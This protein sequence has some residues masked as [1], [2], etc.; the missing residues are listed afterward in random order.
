MYHLDSFYHKT[1]ILAVSYLN[2]GEAVFYL[3]QYDQNAN[4]NLN[5]AVNEIRSFIVL[6]S[7]CTI[8][9][10]LIEG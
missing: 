9:I 4:H 7:T 2:E 10:N 1:S 3:N 6:S 8:V 5:F